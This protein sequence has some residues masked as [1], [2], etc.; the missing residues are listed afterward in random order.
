[1]V[2][3]GDLLFVIDRGPTRPISTGLRRKAKRA[4]AQLKL[5]EIELDRAKDLRSKNTISASEFDQ[6]SAGWQ[7][8][9]AAQRAAQAAQASAALS[10]EYTRITS[11]ID[12]RVSDERVTIGNLIQP[13]SGPD[14][15]L[16]TVVSIDPIYVYVDADENSLLRYMRLSEEGKR[17]SAR[18]AEVPAWVQLGN[19]AASHTKA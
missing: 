1:V 19:E 15:V 7:V 4:A 5:T 14:S 11:P 8:A 18:D 17:K 16:T 3:K 13:G 2:K 6:K 10:L 12:G 9:S